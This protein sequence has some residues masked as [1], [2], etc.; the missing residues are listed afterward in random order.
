MSFEL[1]HQ[2]QLNS[3]HRSVFGQ[4]GIVDKLKELQCIAD[5]LGEEVI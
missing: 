5:T 1:E 2:K 3:V 4:Q